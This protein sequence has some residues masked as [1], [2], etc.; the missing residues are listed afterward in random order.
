MDNYLFLLL[1]LLIGLLLYY[2]KDNIFADKCSQKKQYKKINK[3]KKIFDHSINSTESSNSNKSSNS[4]KITNT[5]YNDIE[6]KLPSLD[7]NVSMMSGILSQISNGSI[8]SI[9]TGITG[10]LTELS[11]NS[12]DK[13]ISEC[14]DN[15]LSIG[16]D[17]QSK[18][19]YLFD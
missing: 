14:E 8:L 16:N 13:L 17:T 2:Y 4:S 15:E 12:N 5:S 7:S 1:I 9:N 11:H 3:Y 10:I 19:S 6:S 18:T